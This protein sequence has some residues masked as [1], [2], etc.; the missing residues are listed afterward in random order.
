M[1]LHLMH[2]KDLASVTA[3]GIFRHVETGVYAALGALL[4]V[5]ALLAL[6]S[7]GMHLYGALIDWSATDAMFSVI[8]RLLVVF[9]LIEILHTVRSSMQSHTLTCEPFLTVALIA[10]VRRILVITLE[11]AE[12]A[13]DA[14]WTTEREIMFRA[15]MLE[16]CVLGGLTLVMVVSIYLLRL[17]REPAMT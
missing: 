15:T 9:M 11:S 7:A 2:R 3:T 12:A 10:S 5:T 16:L 1:D 6:G 8:E 13:H 14:A 17:K 4:C